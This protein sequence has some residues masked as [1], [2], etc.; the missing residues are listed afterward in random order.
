MRK[1]MPEMNAEF[2]FTEAGFVGHLLNE[3]GQMLM[4]IVKLL[5]QHGPAYGCGFLG[6]HG[7]L[8]LHGSNS[9][10]HVRI[11]RPAA[12]LRRHPHNILRRILDIASLAMYAVLRI[13]L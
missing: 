2:V 10:S 3:R 11:V 6:N 1:Y 8:A 12:T 7:D 13:D 5:H 4:R 9:L